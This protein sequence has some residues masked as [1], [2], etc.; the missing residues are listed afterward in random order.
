MAQYSHALRCETTFRVFTP[1]N[2]SP[3]ARVG[4]LYWLSG[5]TCTSEN[6]MTKAGAQRTLAECNLAMVCPDTS[7]RGADVPNEDSYDMGQGA[8]FYVDA[9]QEPWSANF[10]MYSHVVAE[11]P[12]VVAA[13]E[14]CIDGQRAGIFGHSMG[15]H[16]AL[17]LGLRNPQLYRSISAFAPIC[18][19][20]A[21]GWGRKA[22][23]AYLGADESSWNAYNA[24]RLAAAYGGPHRSL[25][26]DQGTDDDYLEDELQPHALLAAVAGS[27]GAVSEAPGGTA[28]DVERRAANSHLDLTVRMRGGYDHGYYFISSFIDSHIRHHAAVLN[29]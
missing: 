17:V 10:R 5:L 13:C 11:L 16:G 9:T 27:A 24:A 8:G 1:P 2:A 12:G 23:S 21:G 22:F 28:G 19:P 3:S 4:V 6:V 20:S 25:L 7:P 26:I 15:G 18:D 29:A 14:P